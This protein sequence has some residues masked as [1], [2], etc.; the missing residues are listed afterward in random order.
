MSFDW[1]CTVPVSYLNF[2]FPVAQLEE[3]DQLGGQRKT[4]LLLS[5]QLPDLQEVLRSLLCPQHVVQKL[6][7]A[8]VEGVGLEEAGQLQERREEHQERSQ[9]VGKRRYSCIL[10]EWW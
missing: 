8:G 3:C 2:S 9:L 4:C 5:L 1:V 6:S 10:C 7:T